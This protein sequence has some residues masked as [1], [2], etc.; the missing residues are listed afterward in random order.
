VLEPRWGDKRAMTGVRLMG[1]TYDPHENALEFELEPGDHR[2]YH[3][4][5]VWTVEEPDGFVSGIDLVRPDGTR[6]VVRVKRVG[7]QRIE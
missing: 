5:E 1:I 6:E 2:V 7:L 3:P 4:E